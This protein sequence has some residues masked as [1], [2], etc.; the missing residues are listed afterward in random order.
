VQIFNCHLLSFSTGSLLAANKRADD[1]AA[2]LKAS[3]E[4]RK[5]AEKD[6]SC[7][8]DLWNRLHEAETA[9]SDKIA[10]NIAHE[11]KIAA[12]LESLNRR[13]VSK[14]T[15][16]ASSLSL[17]FRSFSFVEDQNFCFSRKNESRFCA[18][19]T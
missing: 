4:S 12:R 8:E 16:P 5:K 13:F 2:K 17:I 10:Q 11:G 6:A 19:R 14:F 3:E 7:I 15:S 18:G 9:L 1:L